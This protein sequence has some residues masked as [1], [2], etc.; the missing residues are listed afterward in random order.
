MNRIKSAATT[1]S[2]AVN[3]KPPAIIPDD[4][5]LDVSSSMLK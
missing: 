5:D 4:R 2:P 1:S 3:T